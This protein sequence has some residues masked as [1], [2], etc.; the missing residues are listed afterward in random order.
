MDAHSLNFLKTLLST[1]GPS[2]DE[3]AAARVWREEAAAFADEIS[4]DV[5][6][7]SFAL[8]KGGAP[9]VLL[10]GHIDE[11]GIMVTHIDAEGFLW[12]APIGGWD[13]QV[14]VGQRVRLLGKQG[15]V[16]GVIG[17]KAIHLMKADE[18]D[19]ASKIED[20]WIDIGA[21][22]KDESQAQVRVGT[23]GV[24]D[25]AVQDFPNGRIVSRS[26]DNRIGALTVLE[27]LRL[28]AKDRPTATVA[29]VATVQEENTFGG[30]YAAAFSFEPNVALVVDVTHATDQPDANKR[31][32]GEISL[33]G[34]PAISRGSPCNPVLFD[35][36]VR[37]AEREGIPYS[38]EA[39]PNRTGTDADAMHWSRSGVACG[40]ISIPNR[41]MHSPNEMIQLS[42]VDNA[43]RLIAAL[44]RELTTES[45]FIPS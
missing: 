39:S 45:S 9:R 8:L 44:V 17:K 38:V 13:A 23:V 34:G 28:L 21:L 43:A 3:A 2:G 32:S 16:I 30:A 14:F 31:R 15:A 20:M 7:N 27:A 25:S 22:N 12:F 10:A 33:G 26:I 19:H 1:P 42:D 35:Q 18:R 40:V 41:Y 4:V 29:A 36:L 24:I 5:Q 6:G 37:I 11:I